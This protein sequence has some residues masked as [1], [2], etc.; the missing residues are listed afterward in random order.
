MPSHAKRWRRRK[1]RHPLYGPRWLTTLL[2]EIEREQAAR[3]SDPN[4]PTPSATWLLRY[5]PQF[6]RFDNAFPA[7]MYWR[8]RQCPDSMKPI[9]IWLLGRR[10][11]RIDHL[12]LFEYALNASPAGRRHAARALRRVEAWEKLRT[13]AKLSPDDPKIR[14][15]AYT[16][17]AKRNFD[18]R[19]RNFAEH[20]DHSHAAEGALPSRMPLWFAN[21]DWV[22]HPPKPAEFIRRLLQRIHRLVHGVE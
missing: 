10:A 17:V 16:P 6:R 1:K 21:F 9:A 15:Y 7:A 8:L 12:G 4:S 13:L 5:R 19:L 14:W 11:L 3:L 20:V 22:R 18:E 2:R